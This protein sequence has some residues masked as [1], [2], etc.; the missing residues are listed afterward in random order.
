MENREGQLTSVKRKGQGENVFGECF[1]KEII[2][3]AS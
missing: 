3:G 2:L 1:L